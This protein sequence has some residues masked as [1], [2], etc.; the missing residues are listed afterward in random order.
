MLAVYVMVFIYS[1]LQRDQMQKKDFINNNNKH[2]FTRADT[3]VAVLQLQTHRRAHNIC[4]IYGN[5]SVNNL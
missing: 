2:T 5:K 1:Y 4:E 3:G